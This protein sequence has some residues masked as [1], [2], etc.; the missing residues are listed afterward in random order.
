MFVKGRQGAGPKQAT[1]VPFSSQVTLLLLLPL[2]VKE[3]I[4]PGTIGLPKEE[5]LEAR[6]VTVGS[7]VDIVDGIFDPFAKTIPSPVFTDGHVIEQSEEGPAVWEKVIEP[8]EPLK[9]VIMII[10]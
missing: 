3:I 2:F 4:T 9:L 1:E 6:M 5:L 7:H 8:G 10:K